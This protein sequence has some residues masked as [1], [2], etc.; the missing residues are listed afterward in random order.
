VKRI[1][2]RA[3]ELGGRGVALPR[4]SEA[5]LG[6]GFVG[7]AFAENGRKLGADFAAK[8]RKDVPVSAVLVVKVETVEAARHLAT[9]NDDVLVACGEE[10]PDVLFT[11][12]LPFVATPADDPGNGHDAESGTQVFECCIEARRCCDNHSPDIVG[13]GE[14][15]VD[16]F[17]ELTHIYHRPFGTPLGVRKVT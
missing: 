12:S 14:S 6:L 10:L 5:A 8:G 3:V 7:T 16:F 17:D 4:E 11:W 15:A 2:D 1:S 9:A 13:D